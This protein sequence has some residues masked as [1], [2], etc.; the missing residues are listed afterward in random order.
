MNGQE[1]IRERQQGGG[2]AK[3]RV[4]ARRSYKQTGN[5]RRDI[6]RMGGHK[7]ER[8]QR[9]KEL[10]GKNERQRRIYTQKRNTRRDIKTEQSGERRGNRGRRDR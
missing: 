5:I 10:Y 2:G 7:R 9:E 4:K 6:D 3:G 8:Q 1:G